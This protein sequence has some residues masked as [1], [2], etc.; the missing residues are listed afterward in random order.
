[1]LLKALYDVALVIPLVFICPPLKRAT[2]G[3]DLHS[4]IIQLNDQFFFSLARTVIETS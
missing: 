2:Y 1:M 3:N 4:P